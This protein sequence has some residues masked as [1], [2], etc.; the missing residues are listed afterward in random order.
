MNLFKYIPGMRADAR[1]IGETEIADTFVKSTTE[2]VSLFPRCSMQ[3]LILTGIRKT[4]MGL[5]F[6]MNPKTLKP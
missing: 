4:A 1:E 6:Y 5:R 2:Q 3:D